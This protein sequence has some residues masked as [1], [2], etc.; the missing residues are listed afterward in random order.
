MISVADAPVPRLP[1]LEYDTTTAVSLSI[2]QAVRVDQVAFD[3]QAQAHSA[4]DGHIQRYDSA[5]QAAVPETPFQIQMFDDFKQ[6]VGILGMFS[7]AEGNNKGLK[8]KE[9]EWDDLLHRPTRL[10]EKPKTLYLTECGAV[11]LTSLGSAQ[12]GWYDGL[13]QLLC[14]VVAEVCTEKFAAWETKKQAAAAAKK[15]ARA[16]PRLVMARDVV[17]HIAPVRTARGPAGIGVVRQHERFFRIADALDASGNI[18][19]RQCFLALYARKRPPQVGVVDK[20]CRLVGAILRA[21]R[22][23]LIAQETCSSPFLQESC[24][25]CFC[26]EMHDQVVKSLL[27]FPEI[28]LTVLKVSPCFSADRGD[29]WAIEGLGEEYVRRA[30]DFLPGVAASSSGSASAPPA[31]GGCRDD[32]PDFSQVLGCVFRETLAETDA[33]TEALLADDCEVMMMEAVDEEEEMQL[34]D[35][36]DSAES[37]GAASSDEE[38]VVAKP[39]TDQAE[40][41]FDLSN[42]LQKYDMVDVSTGPH[43]RFAAKTSPLTA[44]VAINSV[45][46]PSSRM[47]QAKV[48]CKIHRACGFW[49]PASQWSKRRHNCMDELLTWTSL[50]LLCS[51]EAHENAALALR[52]TWG[53][54]PRHDRH[55]EPGL[56]AGFRKHHVYIVLG[57][58]GPHGPQ[59]GS[60]TLRDF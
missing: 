5:N 53:V 39:Q 43:Y 26:Y 27:C 37:N 31:A 44:I 23:P 14:H 52:G 4:F 47:Q 38:A 36:P 6:G 35:C 56:R 51:P 25:G 46:R 22:K 30:V 41:L 17:I 8:A 13:L 3:L 59:H 48:N 7:S 16:I 50:G 45:G 57:P 2:P 32:V 33:V 55:F 18:P 11:C 20:A 24:A 42:L 49:V 1:A 29:E 34:H 15:K 9:R 40:P 28:A 19:A 12:R 60:G 21:E 10:N 58:R 54:V